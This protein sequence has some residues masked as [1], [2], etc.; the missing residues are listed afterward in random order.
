MVVLNMSEFVTG[1]IL[2]FGG[3]LSWALVDRM[4][5]KSRPPRAVRGAMSSTLNAA[6]VISLGLALQALF[7]MRGHVRL[8]GVSPLA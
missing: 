1:L 4:S 8:L 5:L 2:L 6:V 7:A 3:F